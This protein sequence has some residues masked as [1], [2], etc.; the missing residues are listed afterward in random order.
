MASIQNVEPP[1][2]RDA[3]KRFTKPFSPLLCVSA[4]RRR[5]PRVGRSSIT[6]GRSRRFHTGHRSRQ[7]RP[8][9]AHHHRRAVPQGLERSHPNRI[10]GIQMNPAIELSHLSRRYEKP[11]SWTMCLS[12]WPKAPPADSS[13][14]TARAKPRNLIACRS[15]RKKSP[16]IAGLVCITAKTH[17]ACIDAAWLDDTEDPGT[18]D[19]SAICV[20][21]LSASPS[22]F[23]VICRISA[24]FAR[25]SRW[26]KE[27]TDP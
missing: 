9:F 15:G 26:A 11:M 24:T 27:R 4:V 19:C 25:P 17:H 18:N 5:S 1:R 23:S 22:S 3:E 21:F 6:G 8:A 20:S 13:D 2:R 7:G 16:A 12:A 10:G 14:L